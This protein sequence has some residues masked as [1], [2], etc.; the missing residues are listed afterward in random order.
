MHSTSSSAPL[1]SLSSS[2]VSIHSFSVLL[3]AWC[4]TS[5][6]CSIV[7]EESRWKSLNPRFPHTSYSDVLNSRQGQQ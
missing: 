1:L 3:L 2:A 6:V 7:A 4:E 5:F